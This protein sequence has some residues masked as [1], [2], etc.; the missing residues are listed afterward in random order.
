MKLHRNAKT[1]PQTLALLV[2]RIR[3]E[4][5]TVEDAAE[6]AGISV[7]TTYK[8][9]RRFRAGGVAALRSRVQTRMTTGAA[10]GSLKVH[11]RAT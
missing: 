10:T 7:R 11:F 1:T 5:W 6:A 8:W 3:E 2:R 9:L 4:H